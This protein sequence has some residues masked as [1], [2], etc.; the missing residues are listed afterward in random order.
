MAGPWYNTAMERE[1]ALSG[2]NSRKKTILCLVALGVLLGLVCLRLP[3]GYDWSDEVYQ[4]VLPYRF[5]LGDRPIAD[6]WEVHQFSGLIALPFLRLFLLF[7]GGSTTGV[8]LY[9]RIVNVTIQAAVALYAFFVLRRRSGDVP[10]MLSGGLILMH[11]HYAM[12]NFFYNSMTLLFL[13][14]SVLLLFDGLGR[15]SDLGR[16][17]GLGRI[18]GRKAEGRAGVFFVLSGSAFALAVQAYPYLLL[19]V[20]VWA[21]YWTDRLR[22]QRTKEARNTLFCWLGGILLIL[23]LFITYL[24][25]RCAPGTLLANV[26]YLFADP[27]HTGTDVLHE[28]GYYVNAARVLFGPVFYGALALLGVGVGACYVKNGVLK[29]KLR[30]AGCILALVLAAGAVAWMLP[31]DYPAY[32]KINLAAMALSL[33]GPGL[34]FLFDRQRNRGLLLYFLGLALSMAVQL[35]SNTRV[36]ASFGMMLPASI[37]T[38]LYLFDCAKALL[39]DKAGRRFR[40]AAAFACGVQL[41]FIGGL[42]LTAVYRDAPISQLTA[43]LSDGPAKGLKTT[44]ESA[45]AYDAICEDIIANAPDS[46]TILMT[47]LMPIGYLLTEL[48]PATPSAYN[49]TMDAGWL[50]L[51]YHVH[52][53]RKPDYIF[54]ADPAYGV[55]NADSMLG[56][57]AYLNNPAYTVTPVDT[58]TVFRKK[59]E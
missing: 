53:E 4:A 31:Y 56:A 12:N 48:T 59:T 17:S 40:V 20:P 10:A 45:G 37:G 54:A 49:M 47:N 43:T 13:L 38:M 9:F 19:A 5:V 39:P 6:T 42:R 22:R 11:A 28:L 50:E 29:E 23:A 30:T 1:T 34:Y 33:L 36:R 15:S 14:L 16:S 58:G 41:L 32:H 25:C 2:G 7:S 27:D 52:P 3:Y 35:G 18:S 44:P 21:V 51:Y 46:G 8:L 55:S 26:R 24:L 57:E